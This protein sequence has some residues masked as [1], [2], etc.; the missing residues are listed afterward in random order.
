[1]VQV[2]AHVFKCSGTHADHKIHSEIACDI[3]QE[4]CHNKKY[5]DEYQRITCAII[6][7]NLT[8]VIVKRLQQGVGIQSKIRFLCNQIFRIEHDV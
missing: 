6:A 1:M 4:K 8:H 5:A 7:N 2:V 3:S